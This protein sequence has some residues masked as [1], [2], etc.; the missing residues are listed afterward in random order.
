MFTINMSVRAFL[1]E[2]LKILMYTKCAQYIENVTFI[3]IIRI[4][5]M[6]QIFFSFLVSDYL[7]FVIFVKTLIR[8]NVHRYSQRRQS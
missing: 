3:L 2:K 4:F 1:W 6:K 7:L 8:V 5:S